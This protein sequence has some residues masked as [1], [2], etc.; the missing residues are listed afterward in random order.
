MHKLPVTFYPGK[1]KNIFLMLISLG[2]VILGISLL[3][4]NI[5]IAVLNIIFFGLC[6]IVYV[7]NFIPNATYLKLSEKGI[8]MKTLFKTTFIPW[9]AIK[10]FGIRNIVIMK[11]VTFELDENVI[12]AKVKSKTGAFPDTYGMSPAKFVALLNEY[13]NNLSN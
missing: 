1:I 13:K 10:S 5:W 11:T 3:D 12:D 7:I 4:K 2:F 6:F 9:R 8:E